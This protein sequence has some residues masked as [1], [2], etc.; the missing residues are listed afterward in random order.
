MKQ[1]F[2]DKRVLVTGGGGG[3][4]R[5]VAEQM[6]LR[7]AFVVVSDLHAERAGAVA[8][9][10]HDAGGRAR[11]ASLDVTDAAAFRQLVDEIVLE[12][13][14]IDYLFN[15]AGIGVTGEVRDLPDGAWDRVVDVN[16]RG[17]VH[18]V[19]AVYPHMIRQG[20]GHIFNTACIAGLVPLPMTAPYCATKHAVVALSTALRSEA[21]ALGVKVSV[22]CPGTVDTGMFEAIEYF[23]VDKQA[24]MTG[25]RPALLP[26]EKCARAILAGVLR[27]KAII[28]ITLHA[29][30]VWWL[31]RLAPRTFLWVTQQ[32]YSRLRSRLRT[33]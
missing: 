30:L 33:D 4:G 12:H 19:E 5:A 25:I 27:N 3:I 14:R 6:A 32:F 18:G 2:A 20:S 10:I 17:V 7:G 24:V 21:A 28:T 26:V 16:L 11:A 15:N 8:K 22:V 1:D 29:R 13:G 31:Y 23:R 9:T